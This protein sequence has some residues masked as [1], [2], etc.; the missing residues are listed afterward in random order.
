MSENKCADHEIKMLN[1]IAKSYDDQEHHCF[2]PL[3]D[4]IYGNEDTW[5]VYDYVYAPCRSLVK[6]ITLEK[7][8]DKCYFQNL[9]KSLLKIS[10]ET[11]R[12]VRFNIY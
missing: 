2:N 8:Y 6:G 5:L 10:S 4:V 11:H 12:G 1:F 7:V 9:H 3:I